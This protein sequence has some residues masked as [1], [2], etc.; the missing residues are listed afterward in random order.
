MLAGAKVTSI[1]GLRIPV[2]T[3][4]QGTVPTPVILYTSWRGSLKGLSK[5]LTGGS[6]LSSAS[7]TVPRHV[8]RSLNKVVSLESRVC[9]EVNVFLLE[10]DLF[11]EGGHFSLDIIESFF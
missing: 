3:L 11:K 8:G 6:I 2:S 10:S 4:P 7:R 5:G 1:P 9:N